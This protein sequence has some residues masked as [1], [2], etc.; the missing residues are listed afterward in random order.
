MAENEYCRG[1]GHEFQ[2]TGQSSKSEIEA[3]K[4]KYQKALHRWL[5]GHSPGLNNITP[6]IGAD[7]EFVRQWISARFIS[8]MDW[9][10]Y[11][12]VWVVSHIVPLR[13]FD[14]TNEDDLKIGLYYKN[15]TPIFKQDVHFKENS[16]DLSLK[17]LEDITAC[18][19]TKSLKAILLLENEK[20]NKYILNNINAGFI[21]LHTLYFEMIKGGHGR[22]PK[23]YR[24]LSGNGR[25]LTVT[26]D[27]FDKK[28]TI[29]VSIRLLNMIT[30]KVD[31]NLLYVSMWTF[32][33]EINDS[34]DKQMENVFNRELKR[35]NFTIP[36]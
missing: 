9:S 8:G 2:G 14:L 27:S 6:F 15:L 35:R 22:F 5:T 20:S 10:N 25:I 36:T 23:K 31:K 11:G 18:E 33:N 12:N 17:I 19:V 21:Y 28:T 3:T 13:F 7:R 24:I 1:T 30:T 34:N 16:I 32:K 4:N 26:E 29:D